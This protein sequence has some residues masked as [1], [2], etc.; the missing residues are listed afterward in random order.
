MCDVSCRHGESTCVFVKFF[1]MCR[2]HCHAVQITAVNM[3]KWWAKHKEDDVIFVMNTV[4]ICYYRTIQSKLPEPHN[5]FLS[6]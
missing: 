6:S 1:N 3:H 2:Q 5:F 4:T